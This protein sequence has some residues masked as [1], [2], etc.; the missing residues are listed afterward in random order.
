[1]GSQI[2]H[3]NICHILTLFLIMAR[4]AL[5]ALFC[6]VA[7]AAALPSQ[8]M[9][10]ERELE[11]RD[12]M[13]TVKALGH[14]IAEKGKEFFKKLL[15]ALKKSAKECAAKLVGK[16]DLEQAYEMKELE[17]ALREVEEDIKK[18]E[19]TTAITAALLG[20]FMKVKKECM[21]HTVEYV[22]EALLQ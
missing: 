20:F 16:R 4:L 12:F 9:D 21:P 5:T 1:M 11:E 17:Y 6:L 19:G 18:R 15:P 10:T 3:A 8:L 13:D 7:V 2:D 14:K 22:K